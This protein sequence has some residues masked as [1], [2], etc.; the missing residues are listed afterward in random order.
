MIEV[1]VISL[2]G[3]E[4]LTVETVSSIEARGGCNGFRR[5]LYWSGKDVQGPE[6]QGW[7]T[8]SCP[9]DKPASLSVLRIFESVERGNHLLF[10]EDDVIPCTNAVAA[11]NNIEIPADAGLINLFDYRGEWPRPGMFIAPIKRDMWGSQAVLIPSHVV[12]ALIIP[13]RM[14]I[15][16]DRIQVKMSAQAAAWDT[17]MGKAVEMLGFR[18][19]HHSPSLFQHGGARWSISNPGARHPFAKN[20]PGVDHD[21]LGP[22]PDPIV[23]GTWNIVPRTCPFHRVQHEG[24]VI[25]NVWPIH[26]GKRK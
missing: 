18:V 25:C 7:E 16:H 20:F 15:A 23:T 5:R 11:V 21:A 19:Y 1:A 26:R 10:L 9:I 14:K 17:W 13:L 3:R 4:P 2:Q 22:C 24:D 12:E 8:I 6:F